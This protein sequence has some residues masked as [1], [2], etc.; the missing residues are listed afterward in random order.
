[1]LVFQSRCD[2]E[3]VLGHIRI[4][5]LSEGTWFYLNAVV[6]SSLNAISSRQFDY[7]DELLRS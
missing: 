2:A 4:E 6:N 7:I 1:M 5:L 3:A